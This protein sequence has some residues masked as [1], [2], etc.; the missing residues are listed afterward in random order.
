M[1]YK[2]KTEDEYE[3]QGNQ[4]QE[5]ELVTTEINWKDAKEQKRCYHENEPG[6]SFSI[7]HKRIPITKE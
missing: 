7:V 5:Y 4:G 6:I 3:I 2:C 1:T